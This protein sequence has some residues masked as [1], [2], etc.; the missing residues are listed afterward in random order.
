MHCDNPD[1]EDQYKKLYQKYDDEIMNSEDFPEK[2]EYYR[3]KKKRTN[4]RLFILLGGP[5]Q[6][7]FTGTIG[8]FFLILRQ[9]KSQNFKI[10][11]WLLAF[12][13]LFW[14]REF[15]NLFMSVIYKMINPSI[16]LFG[17]DEKK[18]S[19][20]FNIY[21]G[22]VPIIFGVTGLMITLFVI[23]KLIPERY[24]FT[25]ILSGLTGGISGYILWFYFVGPAL[26]P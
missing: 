24:R 14:L 9:R 11:D 1:L 16:S 7:M 25:F 26:L 5:L 2:E 20:F 22:T 6:T 17:G 3:I 13:S 19:Q 23:F 10:T 15:Y 12:I 18:I 8:L 4:D 21:D